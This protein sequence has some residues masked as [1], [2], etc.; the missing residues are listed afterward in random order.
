MS[1]AFDTI[2]IRHL[3]ETGNTIVDE[4]EY[5]L[6]Q[7]LLSGIVI[8]TRINGTLTSKLF[9]INVGTP[10]GDSLSPVLFIIY[11]EHALLKFRLTLP[12][13]TTPFEAE[14]PNK[15]AYAD[16]VDFSGQS[17]ADIRYKIQEVFF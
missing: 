5:R 6:T 12:T 15:E 2:N 8:G 9:T 11:L 17:Y 4:H 13:P 14:I 7:F 16:D 10:E 3:F 1:A